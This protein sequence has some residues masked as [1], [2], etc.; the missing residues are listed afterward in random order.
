MSENGSIVC[1]DQKCL[2]PE[3][4]IC[5]PECLKF[6]IAQR[7]FGA[8]SS[9]EPSGGSSR[10]FYLQLCSNIITFT[11]VCCFNDSDSIIL[12]IPLSFTQG[13]YR[14]TIDARLGLIDP[15][16]PSGQ[17]FGGVFGKPVGP[18][19]GVDTTVPNENNDPNSPSGIML[20]SSDGYFY[21]TIG[22]DRFTTSIVTDDEDENRFGASGNANNNRNKKC[23]I[24][25]E[26]TLFEIELVRSTHLCRGCPPKCKPVVWLYGNS[27]SSLFSVPPPP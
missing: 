16:N 21:I 9:T 3:T 13:C 2:D 24:S 8:G 26:F 19:V 17:V 5:S 18:A 7:L 27:G 6:K 23:A 15:L 1:F 14:Y 10:I 11:D 12:G 22:K 20:S 4:M 25:I